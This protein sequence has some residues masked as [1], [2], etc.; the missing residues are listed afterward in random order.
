MYSPRLPGFEHPSERA[1]RPRATEASCGCSLHTAQ[2]APWRQHDGAVAKNVSSKGAGPA[3]EAGQGPTCCKT[4]AHTRG[5]QCLPERHEAGTPHSMRRSCTL[6]GR[7]S[8]DLPEAGPWETVLPSRGGARHARRVAAM[9]VQAPV[10]CCGHQVARPAALRRGVRPQAGV[11][12][13]V[14]APHHRTTATASAS[15][16]SSQQVGAVTLQVCGAG[17]QLAVVATQARAGH[18]VWCPA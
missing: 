9:H 12:R 6:S 10:W 18:A 13:R 2:S 17:N 15:A 4:G 14:I 5:R 8:A 11:L 3:S 7:G 16:S 1:S